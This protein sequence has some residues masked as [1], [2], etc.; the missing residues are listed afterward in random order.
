MLFI[1]MCACEYTSVWYEFTVVYKI[2]FIIKLLAHK[3]SP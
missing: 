2:V 1:H 3:D